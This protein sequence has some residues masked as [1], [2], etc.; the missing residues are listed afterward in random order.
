MAKAVGLSK[1]F[2]NWCSVCRTFG[3]QI[4]LNY[5]FDFYFVMSKMGTLG[6]VV[7]IRT[8]LSKCSK[9]SNIFLFLFS[10][11]ML[12][13]MAGIHKMLVRIANRED[14]DPTV[15]SEVVYSIWLET[16]T[17]LDVSG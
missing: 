8:Y 4:F 7:Y 17:V 10:N 5:V 15:S 14:P 3:A 2:V 11:K 6:P 13:L 16:Q 1:H 12:V 9:I